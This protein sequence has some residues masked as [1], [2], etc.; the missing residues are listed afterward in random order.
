MLK[1]N[2]I[3]QAQITGMTAEGSGV[4][5][6][7]GMAVFVPMTA[8]G[9]KLRVK[10][11][12]VL[13]S[14]A[15]GIIEELTEPAQERCEPDC[16]V[17][18]Q[19]GGCVFRHVT[20]EEELRYKAEQVR[21]AFTR[22]GRLSPEFEEIAGSEGRTA[23]RNKAQYPVAMQDGKLVCGFYARH[24]HRVIPFTG[25]LLQPEIF[26]Q[27]L[28]YL[29]P[30][31]QNAG[32]SAYDE[33]TNTGLLRHIYLRRGYHSG[34]I[35][36]CLV[37]RKSIRRKVQYLLADLQSR[38]P[39]LVSI[40]ENIN[41]E[42]TNVILGKT[43]N[44][45]AGKPVISDRMC[46]NAIE[47]SPQSFYQVNT[48]QAERL[49]GIAKEY[50]QLS[51]G[52]LLLDLYCGAGTIG[53]SMADRA[54]ELIGA[55]VIPEAVENARENALRNGI[56]NAQFHCGDAGEIAQKLKG[57]GTAPDVVVLDPPRKGCDIPCID[58]VAAMSPKRVVM[59]SCNP[60][61]AARD[62]ALFAERGYAVEKV[63]AVDL[64]PG[65]GHVECV[66]LMSRDKA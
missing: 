7:D 23:Y 13:K 14:Y 29:L 32:I 47:I 62:A 28:D 45:L 61:T 49:Y 6:I 35:A 52:E 22:I 1:K 46:G 36:L 66:V 3:Y 60:S 41:P 9:D 65:T 20:Y 40:T 8:V 31:L 25:C 19:C 27:I 24:S 17:F 63:R 57:E 33:R 54:G 12:K 42:K 2:E 18:R 48:A 15:F 16:P 39:E 10:I 11:V 43:L 37:V 53:L 58:A 51:G 38:F 34:E 30:A 59:I 50:A 56:A 21:D 4:C 64:F 26:T 5:R 44:V 55:E